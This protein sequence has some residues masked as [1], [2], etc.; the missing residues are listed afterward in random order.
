MRDAVVDV[1]IED[2][3]GDALERRRDRADLGKDV[4]VVT[5]VLDQHWQHP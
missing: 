4:D 1:V 3:V 5:V 2:F